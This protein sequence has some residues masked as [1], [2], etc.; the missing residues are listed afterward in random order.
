MPQTI[1]LGSRL[2]HAVGDCTAVRLHFPSLVSSMECIHHSGTNR[3]ENVF[4]IVRRHSPNLTL[5]ALYRRLSSSALVDRMGAAGA[6][7]QGYHS[8]ASVK[9]N[10]H[11]YASFLVSLTVSDFIAQVYIYMYVMTCVAS[12]FQRSKGSRESSSGS[13]RARLR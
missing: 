11:A 9:A 12:I 5:M 13:A 3:L 7:V 2:V 1:V 4:N 6:A 8:L 10:N